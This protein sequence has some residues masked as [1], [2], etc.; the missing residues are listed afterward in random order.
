MILEGSPREREDQPR[1]K[2]K[3][4]DKLEVKYIV[5]AHIG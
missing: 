4:I 1:L 5:K 3:N 2:E